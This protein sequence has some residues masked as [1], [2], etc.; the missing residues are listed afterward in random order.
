MFR[1]P[2]LRVFWQGFHS[3]SITRIVRW[4]KIRDCTG[5]YDPHSYGEPHD[6]CF[7]ARVGSVRTV[8]MEK[9]VVDES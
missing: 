2:D 6:D 7:D 1:E 3:Q 4:W 5:L 8:V 9:V